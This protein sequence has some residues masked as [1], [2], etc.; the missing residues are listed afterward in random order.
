ML[1]FYKIQNERGNYSMKQSGLGIAS[2]ILGIISIL[3]ACIAFGIVPGII[4][5][6]LAIIAL[7]QKDKKHGTAI[8]GLT[9]S[10]IGIIIFAIMALF[11]NSV[12]DSSKES[13][14]TQASVSATTESS[15]AVSEITPESKVE[16]AEVPSGTVISPGYT[17]DADG[18]QVTINDF[19]L[20]YTDYEDEYGWNAPA[21]GT[22]YIMIDVSYQ[23]NSKDDKY[24]SIYDFQCYADDTDCEQNYSVVD[25][26]SLNANLSSGRKTSYKI[27]FVVPQ[28]AQSIELEYETSFWTGNKEVIKLQ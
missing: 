27:A 15:A 11:V 28:D 6:V 22:K 3:T 4:G 12:S 5:A 25:S 13:T 10:I 14:G 23:N 7:C 8:A 21:D 24:V 20:D 19:D 9:C 1:K 16:E 26:S 18:L 2:M 17:F